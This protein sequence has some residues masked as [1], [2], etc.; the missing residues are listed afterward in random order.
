MSLEQALNEN[1]AVL[2]QLIVVLSS[3]ATLATAENESTE[4]TEGK[5]KRRTKAEIEADNAAA[6]AQQTRYWHIAAHN[7]VYEQKPGDQDCTLP[8]AVQVTAEQYAALKAEYAAKFPTGAQAQATGTPAPAPAPSTPAASTVSAPASSAAPTMA[9]ITSK[10]QAIHKRDG[11]PGV[12]KV[13][14]QFGVTR[15][16]DLASK[17]LVEVDAAAEAVLNPQTGDNLFG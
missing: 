7:T 14:S 5:R 2:K 3:G 1:T 13:L 6:A 12:A 10:L 9:S 4:A 8:G 11:N 15:V 16:P 17:N